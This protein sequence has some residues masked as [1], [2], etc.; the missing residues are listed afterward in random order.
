MNYR[1]LETHI[2]AKIGHNKKHN[3]NKTENTYD[4]VQDFMK[5]IKKG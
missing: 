3:T 5:A 4:N 1:N 2:K